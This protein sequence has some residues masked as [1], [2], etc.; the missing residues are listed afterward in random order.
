MNDACAHNA[1][2]SAV[3]RLLRRLGEPPWF[4]RRDLAEKF[5]AQL[6]QRAA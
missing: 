6:Q 2:V 4:R 5:A 1:S 3:K